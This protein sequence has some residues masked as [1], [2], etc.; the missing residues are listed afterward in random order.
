MAKRRVL[1]QSWGS[2]SE[3]VWRMSRTGSSAIRSEEEWDQAK[4]ERN[5]AL[6]GKR[7]TKVWSWA[8]R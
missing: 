4:R 7:R 6:R 1:R 8:R 3:T 5:I 2:V